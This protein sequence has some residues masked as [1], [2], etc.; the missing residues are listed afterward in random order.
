MQSDMPTS[1]MNKHCLPVHVGTKVG[2]SLLSLIAIQSKGRKT[3]HN[4][5]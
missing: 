4:T 1:N 3:C 5:D 2:G